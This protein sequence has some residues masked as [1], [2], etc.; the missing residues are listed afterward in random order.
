MYF[1]SMCDTAVGQEK[2]INLSH[3]LWRVRQKKS[4]TENRYDETF[5]LTVLSISREK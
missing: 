5:L 1:E 4:F 3:G 2:R